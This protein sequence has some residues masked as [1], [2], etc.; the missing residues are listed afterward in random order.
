MKDDINENVL[1][2]KQDKILV[3]INDM[4]MT[5]PIYYLLMDL[6]YVIN[7]LGHIYFSQFFKESP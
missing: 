7:Q 2:N 6:T 3:Y 4:K 1:K 5:I